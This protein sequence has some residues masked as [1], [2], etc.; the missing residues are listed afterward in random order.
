MD[1]G[2]DFLH[3]MSSSNWTPLRPLDTVVCF[4]AGKTEKKK[5]N[6]KEKKKKERKKNFQQIIWKSVNSFRVGYIYKL[7]LFLDRFGNQTQQ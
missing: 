4:S 5:K 6:R 2:D 3:E 7:P 1:L